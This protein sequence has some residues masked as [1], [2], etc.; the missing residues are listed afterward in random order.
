MTALAYA[1]QFLT[2]LPQLIQM[3]QQVKELVEDTKASLEKM[4]A[5][6]RNPTPDEWALLNTRIDALLQQLNS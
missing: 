5:E 2:A 1:L 3:T 6:G 4:Q